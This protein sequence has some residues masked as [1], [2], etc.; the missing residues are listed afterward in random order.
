MRLNTI[1]R[2]FVVIT[3]FTG[4]LW[5][6]NA[7]DEG[8][9]GDEFRI[10]KVDINEL[11]NPTDGSPGRPSSPTIDRGW[12]EIF[13]EYEA[14]PIR[15]AKVTPAQAYTPE[16][17]FNFL[18]GVDDPSKPKGKEWY[19][20]YTFFSGEV[21]FLNVYDGSPHFAAMYIHPNVAKRFGGAPAFRSSAKSFVY[22]EV[23]VD[24]KL[25]DRFCTDKKLLQNLDWKTTISTAPGSLLKKTKTPWATSWWG[26]YEM[27][28]E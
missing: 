12:V 25:K 17:Q 24:G 18:V 27:I 2:I 21:G 19:D 7:Q 26:T 6:V 3:V 15:E 28:K 9:M 10:R 16:V 11:P 20:S 8:P 14:R 13:V 5:T 23:L 22:V 1:I 4:L